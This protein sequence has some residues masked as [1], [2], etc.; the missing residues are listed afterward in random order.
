MSK[1]FFPARRNFFKPKEM[2]KRKDSPPGPPSTFQRAKFAGL[3]EPQR[4]SDAEPERH[5]AGL[6]VR[7]TTG[8]C[9]KAGHW[10]CPAGIRGYPLGPAGICPITGRRVS[11]D[12]EYES[13]SLRPQDV[14]WAVIAYTRL[15][16]GKICSAA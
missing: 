1:L 7:L 16:S 12:G 13:F 4:L 9:P 10:W 15:E 6:P 11:V 3:L 5:A 2:P 8:W 14:V